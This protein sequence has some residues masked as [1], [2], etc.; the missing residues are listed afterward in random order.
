MMPRLVAFFNFIKPTDEQHTTRYERGEHEIR[1]KNKQ[2]KHASKQRRCCCSCSRLSLVP[3]CSLTPR[4][5]V[6]LSGRRDTVCELE[7]S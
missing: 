5:E 3:R 4:L 7:S 2:G 6:Q 1:K